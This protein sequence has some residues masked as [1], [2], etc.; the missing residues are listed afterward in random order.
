MNLLFKVAYL[1]SKV[2]LKI[3]YLISDLIFF[4][5]YYVPVVIEEIK[6]RKGLPQKVKIVKSDII[7]NVVNIFKTPLGTY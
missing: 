3:L 4:V 1:F 5:M 6:K 7:T 2:P